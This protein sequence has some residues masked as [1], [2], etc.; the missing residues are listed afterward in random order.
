MILA[1]ASTWAGLPLIVKILIFIFGILVGGFALFF[2][3]SGLF[4]LFVYFTYGKM[5]RGGG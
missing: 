5:G 4:F 1:A 3:G 2:I